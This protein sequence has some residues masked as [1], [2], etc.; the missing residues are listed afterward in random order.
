MFSFA[1]LLR[2]AIIPA[3]MAGLATQALAAD[4]S[5]T[6]KFKPGATSA[7]LS[8]SIKGYDGM[9][10]ILGAQADQVM[11]VTLKPG[12]ASCYFNVLPPGSQDEAIFIGST[13]GNSFAGTLGVG[14]NYTVQVYLMRNAAR[15][16]ETCK[17]SIT[18]KISGSTGASSSAPAG[19]PSKNEQACLQAVSIETNN[20]D[21]TLLRTETSE[22]NDA[23]YIGVGP[24]RAE[25][26]CLVK[27]GVVAEV[28]SMTDEGAL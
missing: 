23:V 22:A 9:R 18:F 10:Y 7:T 17:Y 24:N 8:G 11:S 16:D 20:G 12:N 26:R 15:R 2:L 14:G 4:K 27:R 28:M 1:R 25:W 6:V 3:L 21:V 19:M 5:Q 13:E